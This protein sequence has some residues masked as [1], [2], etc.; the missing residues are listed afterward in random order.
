MNR[1]IEFENIT[2]EFKILN[3]REGLKGSI[4]DL[5]SKNY[6]VIR[7]VN[8]ISLSIGKGEIVG[9]LGPNGAGKSTTIKMMTG[10]LEPTS[11]TIAVNGKIPYKNRCQNARNIG[12]VFGQRTQLWWALPMIESLKIL[13]DIYQVSDEAYKSQLAL[14]ESIINVKPL[15]NKTVREM[16]L[17]QRTLCDILAAFLHNPSVIFLDEPTIGLDVSM[18]S[19]IR[20]LIKE[21]NARQKTT[22][23]LTTHDIGDVDALC[24][25]II[26]IDKGSMIYDDTAG[27]LKKYFGAY[28]TL[29][30]KIKGEYILSDI[31]QALELRFL[32]QTS[33]VVRTSEEWISILSKE[34]E[35]PIMEILMF[36]QGFILI[37]D[38]KIEEINTEDIIKKIYEGN[39]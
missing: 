39:I 30:L 31:I 11:G 19:K 5:V 36:M 24:E 15:Y 8:D 13:K 12:V 7:A 26:I 33:M 9:Y 6:S 20:H 17:G 4:K 2:K 22:V 18:K 3:R 16:S 38:I 23:I 34:D 14:Y 29:K 21:L 32:N 1:I 27:N 25:R 37:N 10:V 35:A 28:R